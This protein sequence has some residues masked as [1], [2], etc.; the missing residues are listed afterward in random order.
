MR[1]LTSLDASFLSLETDNAPMHIGGVSIVDAETPDGRL[2]FER[3]RAHV[4]SR[5]HVSHAFTD[6]L[7]SLPL[8]LGRPYWVPAERFDLDAHLER[9]QLPAPGGR[10]EL[11]E[12][13]NW[14]MAQRLDRSR[15]LWHM[16]FVEGVDSIDGV[17]PGSVA[18]I[19]RIHHAAIDGMSGSEIV[20]ALFDPT[21]TPR[22]LPAAPPRGRRPGRLAMARQ[23]GRD[24]FETPELGDLAAGA[25]RRVVGGA[26]DPTLR[27]AEAPPLPFSAPSTRLNQ[28]ITGRR[29]WSWAILPLDR[30]KALRQST[31]AT[32]NDV[33]L[34]LIAGALRRWLES[35][36]QL[37][38]EP[39]VA[40]VPVSVREDTERGDG[41]N[42]VSAMLV[43][44]A[45]DIDDP[46]ERL[47]S[48]RRSALGSKTYHEAIGARSLMEAAE[49][50]PFAVS[51]QAARLYSRLRLAGRHRPIFNLV[52]TNVPGPQVPLYIAGG[53]LLQHVGAAPIFDGI[54]MIV[55]I[56][57]Y[58]GALA[59]AILSCPD[60]VER[61][62][63]ITEHL[64]P[65]LDAL[66]TSLA[67]TRRVSEPSSGA[68]H[69][70]AQPADE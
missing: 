3:L 43:S 31:G 8:G 42:L 5:L 45:T 7:A 36:G 44:L 13:M 20:A 15:P 70:Q 23:V 61:A 50:F 32:V 51:G 35:G 22:T 65:A 2:D 10:H 37:P 30:I 40:M 19:C 66:E 54:G 21:P 59:V 11:E 4:A 52:I 14:E 67:Q 64:L 41:G 28:P 18:V 9:T 16:L 29:T 63:A 17:P 48:V 34:T 33:V 12:L 57:S 69:N 24:L 6:Q 26:L 60:I 53:L 39:L 27:R 46:S 25:L 38:D 56:F 62:S 49:L 58:D 1:R 47:R 68:E 55:P